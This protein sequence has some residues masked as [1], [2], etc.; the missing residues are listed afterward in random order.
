VLLH[1]SQASGAIPWQITARL[2][3]AYYSELMLDQDGMMEHLEEGLKLLNSIGWFSYPCAVDLVTGFVFIKAVRHDI[4]PEVASRLVTSEAKVDLL[5]AFKQEL[6]DNS[7]SQEE[8]GRLVHAAVDLNIRG[9]SSLLG[10]IDS[11]PGSD[12]QVAI[13][14]YREMI[15]TSPLPPLEIKTLGQFTVLSG[16]REIVFPRPQI[17]LLFQMLLSQYPKSIPE[18]QLI[19]E[20]WPSADPFKSKTLLNALISR[21]RHSLNPFQESTGETYIESVDGRV[22]LRLPE[23][24]SYDV[25]E[26]R[27]V[28]DKVKESQRSIDS[29]SQDTGVK[30]L[31]SALLLYSEEFLPEQRYSRFIAERR[32]ILKYSYQKAVMKFA[33]LASSSDDVNRAIVIVEAAIRMD[34]LWHDGVRQL[35]SLYAENNRLI[36]ALRLYREYEKKLRLDLGLSPGQEIQAYF[37][38]LTQP[39]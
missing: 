29:S 24:S 34:P 17:K 15:A 14:R 16:G 27:S 23:G 22:S 38:R 10:R 3:L 21:L 4:L 11:E 32:E 6:G 36:N 37:N 30:S 19:E 2:F 12:T 35:M 18:D 13:S 33:K 39:G 26:F 7:C 1:K 9:L 5:P 20:L 28:T 8:F 31:Y 25:E